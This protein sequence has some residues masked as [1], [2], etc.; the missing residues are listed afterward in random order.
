MAWKRERCSALTRSLIAGQFAPPASAG[1]DMPNAMAPSPSLHSRNQP[2]QQPPQAVPRVRGR[3]FIRTVAGLGVQAAEALEHAHQHGIL[4]RDIKPSNLLV[5]RAGHLWVTDFGSPVSRESNLTQTG[6]MLGT[7]RYMSPE[8]VLGKRVM[9]DTW[10][11]VYSL[12]AT[13][14]ELLTKR[15]VFPDHDRHEVLRRIAQEEPGPS[16][17]NSPIPPPSRQSS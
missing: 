6:D 12:G 16:R 15:P 11:D 9:H 2:G 7:L 8:Q 13:L 14:Y 1:E 5:D 4:H 17:L 10:S 3:S